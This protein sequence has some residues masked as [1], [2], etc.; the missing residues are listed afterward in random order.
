MKDDRENLSVPPVYDNAGSKGITSI[1]TY[2]V[3]GDGVVNEDVLITRPDYSIYGVADGVTSL[4]SYQNE[5]G[6]TGG[7]LAANLVKQQFEQEDKPSLFE[8]VKEANDQLRSQMER[9]HI[10]LSNKDFL[11]GSALCVIQLTDKGIEF[12]QTG[13]CMAFA[14]YTYGDVRV[15]TSRQVLHLEEKSLLKW[16][17]GIEKGLK[18]REDLRSYVRSRLKSNRRFSNTAQGYGV[19]NGESEAIDFLEYG[20]INNNQIQKLIMLTDGLFF[21]EELV[22]EGSGYWEHNIQ[23]LLEK[24]LEKYTEELIELEEDDSECLKYPRFKK[25]DDKAGIILH[26]D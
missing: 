21:P 22:P 8:S 12:I 18:T 15:L 1:E 11:W 10:D 23:L 6:H 2:T 13:D 24:G 14:V 16:K 20:K 17:E 5:E 25:S 26:F 7:Y 19:L 3:K 9:C 4:S